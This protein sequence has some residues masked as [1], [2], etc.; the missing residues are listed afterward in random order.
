[1]WPDDHDGENELP[2]RPQPP[3]EEDHRRAAEA[4]SSLIASV[5]VQRAPELLCRACVDLLPISGA[6]VSI[7]GSRTARALWC[8][9]DDTAARL[10]EAQ[11]TLGHGPCQSAL[12]LAVPALA[13][14]LT[15]GPDARRWPVFALQAVD[16]GARAV[17]A[18]PL[19]TGA[20]TLGTLDLYRDSP[21]PLSA[22][23][24]RIA[25]SARDAV[26]FAVLSIEAAFDRADPTG[27]AEVESWVDAAQ[28]D[29]VEVHQ[30]IGMVMVQLG[31][32]PEHAL[33]RLRA[34]AFTQG[35]TVT[36][37]A[38]EVLARTLC[39]RQ[40]DDDQARDRSRPGDEGGGDR[41]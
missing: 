41:S 6:S 30:A 18:L 13:P 38:R 4:F 40:T 24:L 28:A 37:V 33:D 2:G 12:D 17:F 35:R 23:E 36:E 1:M 7:S 8:A 9:S 15:G 25:L 26:T 32:H 22:G 34:R 5:Q 11:Y 14:D 19:G 3:A 10:A 21:G 16:L 27:R 20:S 31:V 39:F 29:R